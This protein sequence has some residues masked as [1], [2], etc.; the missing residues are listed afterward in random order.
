MLAEMAESEGHV[1][2]RGRPCSRQRGRP[3]RRAWRRLSYGR[4]PGR[5]RGGC[6]GRAS[7]LLLLRWPC[8]A[9]GDSIRAREHDITI[10]AFKR[11]YRRVKHQTRSSSSSSASA[12]DDGGSGGCGRR[13]R[14]CVGAPGRSRLRARDGAG[15]M[16]LLWLLLLRHSCAGRADG[17]AGRL[18]PRGGRPRAGWRPGRGGWRRGSGDT[19]WRGGRRPMMARGHVAQR[20][21]ERPRREG[22]RRLGLRSPRRRGQ[23]VLHCG[24]LERDAIPQAVADVLRARAV[25]RW[26]LRAASRHQMDE[27][28]KCASAA[29]NGTR[30]LQCMLQQALPAEALAL[31]DLTPESTCA[32]PCLVCAYILHTV[33]SR[34]R[35]ALRCRTLALLSLRASD[36][37]GAH[38]ILLS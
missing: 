38:M 26:E 19:G 34:A 35:R 13:Q 1:K 12:D 20:V 22:R 29:M 23:R 27:R 11:A 9:G 8:W 16:L 5:P 3:R 18:R 36:P 6:C 15:G 4:P 31:S 14:G 37:S 17:C 33:S 25:P 30:S 21:M 24:M 28:S 7:L 2:G 32:P 10:A